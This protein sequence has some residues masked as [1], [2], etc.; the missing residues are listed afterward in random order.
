MFVTA[1]NLISFVPEL[2]ALLILYKKTPALQQA[3][4]HA[5]PHEGELPKKKE[6]P[7]RVWFNGWKTYIRQ[8]VLFASLS[9]VC[10]YVTVLNVSSTMVSFL[11]SDVSKMHN[12][13]IA[14]ARALT[15]VTGVMATLIAPRLINRT[16]V[17]KAGVIGIWWQM[18]WLYLALVAIALFTF[19]SSASYVISQVFLYVFVLAVIISRI[20]LWTFDLAE[21]QIMQLGIQEDERGAVNSAEHSL[22]NVAEFFV[23]V[24][25]MLVAK[26][27]YFIILAVISAGF[28]Q[29]AAIMFTCWNF[30]KHRKTIDA[31]EAA[32]VAEDHQEMNEEELPE[33]VVEG[34]EEVKKEDEEL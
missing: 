13:G 32:E 26:P 7:I 17:A 12:I 15:A 18:G 22:F 33:A 9:I 10:L 20:G 11:A 29:I 1:W 24:C 27:Q 28:V 30:T 2:I 14:V 25:S 34:E 4:E 23:L 8:P 3:K 5:E 21:T 16:G 19:I 6:N 31:L